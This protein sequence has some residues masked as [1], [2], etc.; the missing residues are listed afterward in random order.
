M[1]SKNQKWKSKTQE[2][3]KIDKNQLEKSES[4]IP[5]LNIFLRRFRTPKRTQKISSNLSYP[6]LR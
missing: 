1:S 4:Q 2:K 6:S 5:S 3:M